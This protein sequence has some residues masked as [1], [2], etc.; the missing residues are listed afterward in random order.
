MTKEELVGK[1]QN[2]MLNEFRHWQ[3][4]MHA[5]MV[6]RGLHRE[7]MGEFFTKQASS[8]MNHIQQFGKM[9]IGLGGEIPVRDTNLYYT[10]ENKKVYFDYNKKDPNSLL[11]F[12]KEMEAEVVN[13]YTVRHQEAESLNDSDG[14]WVAIFL[15]DQI[16]DSRQDLDNIKEML[17]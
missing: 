12:A 9:I 17:L 6:V 15:E 3:F 14:M 2:D 4:Y 1:L 5:S 16:Q 11:Q 8:E 10:S 7:E 13:N